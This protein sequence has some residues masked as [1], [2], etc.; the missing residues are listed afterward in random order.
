M[1]HFRS[2]KEQRSHTV[3]K[4]FDTYCLDRMERSNWLSAKYVLPEAVVPNVSLSV[5]SASCFTC[6]W[7]SVHRAHGKHVRSHV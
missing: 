6:S 7:H 2:F 5:A 1:M 3:M 4:Y